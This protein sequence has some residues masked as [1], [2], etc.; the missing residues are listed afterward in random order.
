MEGKRKRH[1]FHEGKRE[2]SPRVSKTWTGLDWTGQCRINRGRL[3]AQTGMPF[4]CHRGSR[5]RGRKSRNRRLV[6]H[7][8]NLNEIRSVEEA[9]HDSILVANRGKSETAFLALH[10]NSI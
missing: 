3:P 4:A 9:F 7:D 10:G 2:T 1:L 8:G 6:S 5:K